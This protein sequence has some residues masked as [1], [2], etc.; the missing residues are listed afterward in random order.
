[1]ERAPFLTKGSGRIDLNKVD[2][3]TPALVWDMG[4]LEKR[5]NSMSRFASEQGCELLYSIKASS[6]VPVLEHI[7]GRVAGFSCSS[8]FEAKL[9]SQTLRGN[10]T[11]HLTTPGFRPDE[12][13][14]VADV[15]DYVALNSLSQWK[16]FG[17]QINERTSC[18]LRLNPGTSIVNDQRYDPCRKNSKLGVPIDELAV[19]YERRPE[20]LSNLNG[21]HIHV[22]C[23]NKSFAQIDDVISKIET[24]LGD[25]LHQIDWFNLGGGF[26]FDKILKTAPFRNS[27][28]RL[29]D[30]YSHNVI[31]EPGTA[32][33]KDAGL[34]VCS[35]IDL[36]QSDGKSIAVLD[37]S[38]N[39]MPEVFSYQTQPPVA[40]ATPDGAY[41]YILAGNTCLAGDIFGEYNFSAPLQL[42]ER[43][44]F[45]KR[46]AYTHAQS[47]W[48]NGINLP[49]IYTVSDDGTIKLQQD[50][51]FEDFAHRCAV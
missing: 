20:S 51:I 40:G 43:I 36:F 16:R 9:A 33:V 4:C 17:A 6:V 49:T 45:R 28:T 8:L 46:G 34:L 14:A 2:L 7:V 19:Q 35:V 15:C 41:R 18:G 32:F 47:H 48:F 3:S 37:S 30:K 5:I 31:I 21:L 50:F 25:L 10:G 13:D 12:I 44:I 11:V 29:K 38:V 23:G 24:R 22:A 1:M 39:H 26:Y 27:V 42:G